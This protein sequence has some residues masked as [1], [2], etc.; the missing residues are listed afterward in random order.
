MIRE[1]SG[2][3]FKDLAEAVRSYRQQA[4]WDHDQAEAEAA[5]I[6]ETAAE[7]DEGTILELRLEEITVRT[8]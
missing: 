5:T 7:Y 4:G 6:A 2:Y 3:T 8:A 1:I